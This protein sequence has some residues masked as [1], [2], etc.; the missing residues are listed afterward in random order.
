MG[1]RLGEGLENQD[2]E[3]ENPY[4]MESDPS[5]EMMELP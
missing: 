5:Q 4:P 2:R 1:L 3:N